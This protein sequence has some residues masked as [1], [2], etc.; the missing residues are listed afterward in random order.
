MVLT[1]PH[2]R[3]FATKKATLISNCTSLQG[4]PDLKSVKDKKALEASAMGT[5]KGLQCRAPTDPK[6]PA[7]QLA[8][9]NGQYKL[10][11]YYATPND[12]GRERYF[13]PHQ[14]KDGCG[15]VLPG[16]LPN[17]DTIAASYNYRLYEKGYCPIVRDPFTGDLR[18]DLS[19]TYYKRVESGGV[20]TYEQQAC[21]GG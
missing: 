21:D 7:C 11:E 1:V 17:E 13:D 3:A 9:S 19:A 16:A 2:R 15:T 8:V 18:Y 12:L 4:V 6:P 20:V 14:L 5:P 10:S